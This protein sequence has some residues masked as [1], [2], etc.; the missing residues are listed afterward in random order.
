MS[1]HLFRVV[2][3][4]GIFTTL[5]DMGGQIVLRSADDN[6][7]LRWINLEVITN[8]VGLLL[9]FVGGF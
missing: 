2:H 4:I 8:G 5:I 7:R 9:S 6:L 3:L 1:I